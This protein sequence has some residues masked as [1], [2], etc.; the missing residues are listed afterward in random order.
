MGLTLVNVWQ[1]TTL[2]DSDVTQK[3]VQFLIVSDC[4]L[5][6]TGD[7]TG[8]LVVASGIA[9]QFE[10]FSSEVLKDGSEVDWSTGTDTLGIVAFPQQTMDTANWESETSF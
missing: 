7:D 4:K 2:G 8:L 3:F 10:D 9:G 6:M 5:E 1:N